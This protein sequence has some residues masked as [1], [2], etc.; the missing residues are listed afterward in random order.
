[1]GEQWFQIFNCSGEEESVFDCPRAGGIGEVASSCSHNFDTSVI[2]QGFYNSP[3]YV[4][5]FLSLL[6]PSI[7]VPDSLE[8]VAAL[9]L[10]GGATLYE[11]QLQ[12][13]YNGRWGKVC[14]DGWEETA[15][16]IACSQLGQPLW[17]E[18]DRGRERESFRA[19]LTGYGVVLSSALSF[20]AETNTSD[21]VQ[22]WLDDLACRGNE[23]ALS[24]CPHSMWGA[25]D[26]YTTD[27]AIGLA[28][29][30]KN[31]NQ[32]NICDS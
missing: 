7:A 17:G 32:N 20:E 31:V 4:A 25:H 11:G 21:P 9:R 30:G 24:S 10:V 2:C 6:F 23:T 29:A 16:S 22:F 14:M 18:G 5:I 12:V 19:I 13:F 15:A 1:M 3:V 26:C 28:C 8:E 27:D